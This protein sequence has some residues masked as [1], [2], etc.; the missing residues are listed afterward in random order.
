VLFAAEGIEPSE[1]EPGPLPELLR[2][3][4][5]EHRI[6]L[7]PDVQLETDTAT[8]G[9]VITDRA[10]QRQFAVRADGDRLAV[11]AWDNWYDYSYERG[12]KV[13]ESYW[14][15]TSAR[16]IID[17]G[18]AS[19][20]LYIF[21]VLIGHHG[22][23]SLTPIWLLSVAGIFLAWR[24]PK[25]G[26]RELAVMTAI[27]TLVCLAF[28]LSRERIDRNYGGSTSG[29]RWM[30]WF[31]PLWLLTLLPAADWASERR[32]SRGT[33]LILLAL[34]AL[35]A[36]YPVWNPWTHPWLMYLFQ[37]LGWAEI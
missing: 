36:S 11:H 31:A 17:Q 18:E 33:S 8:P 28:Y 23:F 16:S 1:L 15:T 20:G 9:W 22:I 37:Y 14:R 30:F 29:L 34:S 13:R 24:S 12:G 27:L 10:S 5:E 2:D 32:W 3:E 25:A 21:N 19:R 35:S 7:S 6:A 26:I 4:F